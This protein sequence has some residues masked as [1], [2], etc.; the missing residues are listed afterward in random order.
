[1]L[2]FGQSNFIDEAEIYLTI[3]Q[4]GIL[5]LWAHYYYYYVKFHFGPASRK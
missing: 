5:L 1:V 2:F 3:T 4:F